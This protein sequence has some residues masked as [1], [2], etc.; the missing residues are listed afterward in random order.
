MT[1]SVSSM[2]IQPL[3]ERFLP[4]VRD[5]LERTFG[6]DVT[7]GWYESAFLRW[8]FFDQFPGWAGDRSYVVLQADK[9]VAHACLWPTVFCSQAVEVRCSHILDWAAN[10]AAKGSG[11]AVYKELMALSGAAF[12][13]GGSDQAQRLLPRMGF[14]L[15][16]TQRVYAKVIRPWR[17]FRSRAITSPLRDGARL[18]RNIYWS[19]GTMPLPGGWDA[20]LADRPGGDVDRLTSD[21]KPSS[22]GSGKRSS[23]LIEYFLKCPV[24]NN[25]FYNIK[26]NGTAVGYFILNL[27]GGH[28]RIVD[29]FLNTEETDSWR[30]ACAL[31]VKEACS[32][33]EVCEVAA[34][35]SVPWLAQ[36]LEHCGFRQRRGKPIFLFDPSNQCSAMPPLLVQMVDSDAFFLQNP[37]DPYFT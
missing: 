20:Q 9:V 4:A 32:Y 14:R 3:E 10:P 27:L 18:A 11:V 16:G 2:R 31:A 24:A 36:V 22:F 35:A 23:A 12:V 21:W 37:S 15:Y 17:Q 33:P 8:K 13:V 7:P 5:L 34:Y 30:A 19:W 25:R 28:C 1:T 26:H 6:P 29:I